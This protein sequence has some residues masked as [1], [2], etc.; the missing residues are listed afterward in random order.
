MKKPWFAAVQSVVQHPG[1]HVCEGPGSVHGARAGVSCLEAPHPG[2]GL[3][4]DDPD[5]DGGRG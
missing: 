4:R 5:V 2:G 3:V 1:E